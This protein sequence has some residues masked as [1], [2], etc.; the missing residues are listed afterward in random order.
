MATKSKKA[1]APDTGDDDLLGGEAG[2]DDLLGGE[3]AANG[4]SNGKANGKAKVKAAK[5]PSKASKAPTEAKAPKA[6]KPKAPKAEGAATRGLKGT[7]KFYID[8]EELVALQKKIASQKKPATSR[9]L[10]QKFEVPTWKAR[11]AA[12]AL[13]KAGKGQMT[14]AGSMLLFTPVA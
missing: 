11:S 3:G 13:V 6:A 9:E 2:S 14:K 1:A 12:A 7:G 4:K 10:A 5:A 8:P